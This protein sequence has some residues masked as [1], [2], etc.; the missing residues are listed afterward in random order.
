[1]YYCR[2][3]EIC[4]VEIREL[5]SAERRRIFNRRITGATIGKIEFDFNI[6]VKCVK[7]IDRSETNGIAENLPR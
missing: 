2:I 6:S 7:K 4:I 5:T 1:M 3:V